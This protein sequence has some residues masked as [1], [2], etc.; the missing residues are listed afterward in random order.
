MTTEQAILRFERKAADLR[1]RDLFE[2]AQDWQRR[3]SEMASLARMAEGLP[4]AKRPLRGLGREA[5]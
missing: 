4:A 2:A 5:F 3:A 1:S